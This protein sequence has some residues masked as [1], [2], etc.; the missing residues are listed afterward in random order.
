MNYTF[1]IFEGQGRLI[2]PH[3]EEQ[4]VGLSFFAQILDPTFYKS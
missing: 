4:G 2:I 3:F 1:V